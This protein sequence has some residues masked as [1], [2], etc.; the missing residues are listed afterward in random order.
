MIVSPFDMAPLQW[1]H[2]PSCFDSI[3]PYT[4]RYCWLVG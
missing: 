4:A 3:L 1:L 2:K